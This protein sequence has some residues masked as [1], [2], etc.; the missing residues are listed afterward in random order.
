MSQQKIY[1]RLADGKV[2]EYPVFELH[3]SNRAHPVSWYNEVDFDE[4]PE[5]P[6]FYDL[7][8]TL[9]VLNNKVTASYSLVPQSLSAVLAKIHG[10]NV[11]DLMS[12]AAPNPPVAFADVPAASIQRVIE[13]AREL[14]QERLDAF[15][16]QKNYGGI[17]SAASYATSTNS[18][19]ASE[20]QQAVQARDA[21]W[22]SLYNYLGQ[23]QTGAVPVPKS[24]A[25]IEAVLP[26][27]AWA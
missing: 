23:V 24:A 17:L 7:K 15:A 1:A 14:V 8:E 10:D 27:L 12:G 11:P 2:A 21:T 22:L 20:G 19:F 5:V 26:V 13:L 9:T 16:A 3:I 18:V 6:E 25:D 4:K